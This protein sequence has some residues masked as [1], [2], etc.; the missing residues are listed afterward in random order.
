[1]NRWLGSAILIAIVVLLI[2][3]GILR[4][5]QREEER[6]FRETVLSEMAKLDPIRIDAQGTLHFAATMR[7]LYMQT[8]A[9]GGKVEGE[10]I[11]QLYLS[12]AKACENEVK[13][14]TSLVSWEMKIRERYDGALPVWLTQDRSWQ[15]INEDLKRGNFKMAAA[16]CKEYSEVPSFFAEHI[17][18]SKG[19][20]RKESKAGEGRP[21]QVRE[22]LVQS[23]LE[24]VRDR[25]ETGTGKGNWAVQ[26]N[27]FPDEAEA[28][29]LAN[30]LANKGYDAY[31][32]PTNIKGR[33]WYRVRVGRLAT[34]EEAKTLQETLKKRENFTKSITTS[35]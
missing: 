14:R 24:R 5:Y 31:V 11:R 8:I 17:K 6:R 20:V 12:I 16:D 21:D 10:K 27:A 15:R 18:K 34:Q 35:R 25:A 28:I 7:D 2:G 13:W 30:T 33:D 22:K 26:V 32:V 23:A 19:G 29:T 3:Y 9:L 1:M 4:K